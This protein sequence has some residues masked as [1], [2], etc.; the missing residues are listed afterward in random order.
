M[1]NMW[2][3]AAMNMAKTAVAMM[4][5]QRQNMKQQWCD[6]GR[7]GRTYRPHRSTASREC[8]P[9]EPVGDDRKNILETAL[10]D[11]SFTTLTTALAKADLLGALQR[12]GPFTVFAPTDS[13][14]SQ[15]PT[16]TLDEL[17]DPKNI[18]RLQTVLGFHVVEGRLDAGS[19]S[20]R[21]HLTTT[22]GQRLTVAVKD[23]KVF[24]GEAQ[25]TTADIQCSNGII[26]VVDQVLMPGLDDLTAALAAD[27]RFSTLVDLV[28]KAGLLEVLKK[29]GPFT[30]FAPTNEAFAALPEETVNAL[31]QPDAKDQ[32][33]RV[34]KYHLIGKRV[35]AREAAS[36]DSLRAV[37]D[38]RLYFGFQNGRLT[39]NEATITE[40][41]IETGNGVIHVIDMVLQP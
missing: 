4:H 40:T 25:V 10:A 22:S 12:G 41:D 30:L 14:F 31:T 17:L 2:T 27:A 34:L 23:G 5:Y 19:V 18:D 9:C 11:G 32:L 15:I 38:D 36:A 37:S 6:T 33:G 16:A 39:V 35:F 20:K 1:K 26:H 7:S 8:R 3:C 24:V 13:A 29:G 28:Q 21:R